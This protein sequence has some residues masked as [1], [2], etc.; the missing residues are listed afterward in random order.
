MFDAL[1]ELYDS[2]QWRRLVDVGL[3]AVLV[4]QLLMLVRGSR[5]ASLLLGLGALL[6]LWYVSR[7]DLLDLPTVF[8]V[9]DH[10]IGSAAVL[11]VVLFQDD[12][13]RTLGTAMRLSLLG[14]Q[15][16]SLSDDL[17]EHIVRACSELAERGLGALIVI[18][19]QAPLERYVQEGVD[20]GA[21][22]SWQL[23]VALFIPSFQNPTHDGAAVIQKGRVASAGNFLPLAVG[24]G[25]PGTLGSRH[26]AA[27]GLSDETDAI[28]VVVSEENH[29]CAVAYTGALDA[30]LSPGELRERLRLLLGGQSRPGSWEQPT[31][32]RRISFHQPAAHVPARPAATASYEPEEGPDDAPRPPAPEL[33]PALDATAAMA[34]GPHDPSDGGDDA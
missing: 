14:G 15:R 24:S 10:F 16:S 5:S 22:V 30:H 26:R 18:E 3:V 4:Y 6:G 2:L 27:L 8:W 34:E 33:S 25:I 7:D 1:P 29:T 17:I 12:I 28:V 32:R 9:L 21:Q 19:Q 11:L 13:R 23:L 20:V 31:W